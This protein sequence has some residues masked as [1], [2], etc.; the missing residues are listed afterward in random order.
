MES[1]RSARKASTVP[2]P[3]AALHLGSGEPVLLLQPFM[4]SPHVW[5]RVAHILARSYEVY[6]PALPG[7]WGGL[8]LTGWNITPG[9]LADA[10]E[11]KLDE[12]GWRTCHIAGNSLGGWI[13]F[14]LDQ[15]GRAQSITAIAPA[16][17]WRRFT[18]AQLRVGL[19]FL[20]LAPLVGV[21]KMLGDFAARNRLVQ[22]IIL[23]LI[24][25]NTNAVATADAQA[26]VVAA[27]NCPA[28]LR[29]L[30]TGLRAP[31]LT[32]LDRTQ[33]PV[34]LLLC[35]HDR[36]IPAKTYG[37]MFVEDLPASADRITLRGVGHVP[38]IEDPARIAAL[39]TE[40][41]ESTRPQ[42]RA[43]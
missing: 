12:L 32:N 6:A 25:Q 42:L 41:I 35:D 24:V 11:A 13:A 29:L 14:E 15:R 23:P 10:V 18:P 30:W 33:A 7:H 26:V 9:T 20:S 43:V 31:G 40:H 3:V 36:I 37:R 4:L 34:R 8:P 5:E 1:A 38:M 16:G 2:Q 27:S 17:G 39:I 21:G 22:R 28:Y 19:T